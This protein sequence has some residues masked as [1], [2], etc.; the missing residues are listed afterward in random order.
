MKKCIIISVVI[1]IIAASIA[2]TES[3]DQPVYIQPTE[4]RVGDPDKGYDYL[5]NGDYIKSCVPYNYFTF[6][7]GKNDNNFLNRTGKNANISHDYT[8]VKAT[9]GVE[10]VVPN[11]LQCHAQVFED[12]LYVGLG[13]SFADFTNYA[14]QDNWVNNAS[15]R[16]ARA[17]APKQ[18][19]AAEDL[20]KVFKT[21]YP[22]LQ[23][24]V[25][26]V[27][28]AG[29][30]AALLAAHRDPKT[31]QWNDT[32]LL[33][34]PEEVVPSDVPAWWMLKKKHA[35]F[36]NGFGRGDFAQYLMASNLLTVKDSSEAR[37]VS[38]HFGDVLAYIVSIQPPKYPKPINT[39]LAEKGEIVFIDNCS[40]CH[41][42][43]GKNES[44][45]NL[46]IPISIVQT[47]SALIRSNQQ[48]PQ[49][50]EWFNNSWLSQGKNP[51][52][53]VPFDGYVAP[54]LDGVWIT[55]P[56]F[57]NG[58]V[59]DLESVL[60]SKVRPTYWQRNFEKPEY[61]YDN[62]G[63]KYQEK[64]KPGKKIYNTTLYGYGNHG[65]YF[66]DHLSDAERKAVIEFLKTL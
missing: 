5:I 35:M 46:L 66:G 17:M 31:L 29:R 30:L 26:G 28:T 14:K 22:G 3:G 58:S 65:H 10:V 39:R 4:Q 44:Y 11:C 19:E 27:N 6:M 32:P 9:N 34:I 25:P 56:Y 43:Y 41:G 42:T 55:A 53:L 21:V 52:K 18:F 59:P 64:D 8:V 13:N 16:M 36:Y 24:E 20:I 12:K 48:N 15:L 38:S 62:P 23:T 2:F 45:P 40:R 7:F 50:I 47:D 37:E 54:P 63:W 49:F 60:N 33:K 1:L 61:N 51:A 57:H